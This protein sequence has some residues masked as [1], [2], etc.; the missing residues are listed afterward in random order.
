[1][2]IKPLKNRYVLLKEGNIFDREYLEYI[3]QQLNQSYEI[4][5]IDANLYQQ[6]LSSFS[7][8]MF[9]I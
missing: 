8:F 2:G 1:M 4:K 9:T 6:I 7:W 3:V 5:N